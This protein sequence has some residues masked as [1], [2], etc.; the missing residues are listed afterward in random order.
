MSKEAAD[1][2]ARAHPAFG[3][4]IEQHGVLT[5]EAKPDT[6]Y[7][8]LSRHIVYQQLS[9]KAAATIYG[10][11]AALYGGD[12]PPPPAILAEADIEHLRS[13][14]LSRNKALALIDLARKTDAGE[15]PERRLCE[16]M[17]GDEV[18]QRLTA[19]RG[20]GE[21]TAQM[22]LLFTLARPDIWPTGDLGVRQGWR[23]AAGLED[24]PSPKQLGEIGEA[25]SP[26]RSYAALYLWRAAD[27]PDPAATGKA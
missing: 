22:F 13:A 18:I 24:A 12:G 15:V 4:L 17:D 5:L 27:T 19:V 3:A 1:S 2:L 8:A 6:P 23:K 25:F 9:G 7:E 11:F 26:W 20:I 21:W 14:G 16:S 10:R